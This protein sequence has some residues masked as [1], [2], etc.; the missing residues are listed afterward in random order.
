MALNLI[1]NLP[2]LL[3][4]LS[5]DFKAPKV[6]V[7]PDF[8]MDRLIDLGWEPQRF[9]SEVAAIVER[10]GGSID[11]VP[12]TDLRGGNAINV[13]SALLALGVKVTPIVCTSK[14]GLEQIRFHL[15]EYNI[16]V[17]HI[18]TFEK[19]SVTTALE[20][21]TSSGK[22]NVMLRDVGSLADFGPADLTAEDYRL[23]EDSDYVCLFNWAGTRRQGTALAEAV[24]SR[25]KAKGNCRTYFDTADPTPNKDE[26]PVLM[27]KVLKGSQLDILSVNEN[28]AVTY[29]SL[30]S[31]EVSKQ[32]GKIDFNELALLSAQVLSKHLHARIDLHTTTFSVTVRDGRAVFVPAFKIEPLRATVQ[33]THGTQVTSS[34]TRTSFQTRQIDV[35]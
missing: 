30:L 7:M 22:V 32:R 23:I 35:S 27:Q 31:S 15:Q 24:F 19:A 20:F 10:K 18:K 5:G 8:F 21:K 11:Q 3:N 9:S 14:L 34:A 16:G 33:A 12:Q 13:T 4:F 1:G 26:I 28:E 25:A 17:S 6:V 2:E 29:A